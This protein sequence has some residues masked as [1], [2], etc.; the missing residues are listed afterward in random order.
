MDAN[1]ID[2]ATA[3]YLRVGHPAADVAYSKEAEVGVGKYWTADL[4]GG[5]AV[6]NPIDAVFKTEAMSDSEQYVC[7]V[8]GG[9]HLATFVGIHSHGLFAEHRFAGANCG[10]NV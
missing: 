10:E 9:D 3:S 2:G 8:G 5:D 1:V 7:G 4:P 6:A